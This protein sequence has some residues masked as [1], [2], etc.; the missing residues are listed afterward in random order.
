MGGGF[1]YYISESIYVGF[2]ILH[3][4]TFTDYIDDVSTDYIDPRYFDQYLPP[5]QAAMA[6]Q[7]HYRENILDPSVSRQYINDQR[8]DPRENDAYFSSILRTGWRINGS[9]SPNSRARRQLKC[10]VFY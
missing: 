4:K 5:D 9:G 3:R 8:G 2:E 1:K 10:P 7:L 6:R